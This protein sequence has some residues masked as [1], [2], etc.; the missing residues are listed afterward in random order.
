[1]VKRQDRIFITNKS[2]AQQMGDYATVEE[3]RQEG[4]TVHLDDN[5]KTFLKLN[6]IRVVKQ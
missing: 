1:M 6:E 3:I 4:V 5:K 2:L